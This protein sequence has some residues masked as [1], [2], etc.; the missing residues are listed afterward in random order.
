MMP[1]LKN[2]MAFGTHSE[3]LESSGA[4]SGDAEV[5]PDDRC[6]DGAE[7]LYG[8]QHFLVWKRGDTHLEGDAGDAAENFIHIKEFFRDGF[9][10][11][12]QQRSGR[13]AKGIVLKAGGRWP[14]AGRLATVRRNMRNRFTEQETLG[15]CGL[16]NELSKDSIMEGKARCRMGADHKSIDSDRQI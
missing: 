2:G 6:H 1:A 15:I 9:G 16:T 7:Y 13:S 3:E 12:D 10:V 4:Y 5:V 8:V 14:A 11:A